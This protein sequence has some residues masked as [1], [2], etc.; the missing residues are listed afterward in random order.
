MRDVRIRY[1]LTALLAT[2]LLLPGLLIARLTPAAVA[3]TKRP[4]S[5]QRIS[6]PATTNIVK[7][8]ELVAHAPW[9]GLQVLSDP[10]PL[11]EVPPAQPAPAMGAAAGILIDVD[12]GGI[13]WQQNPHASLPP[14]STTKIVTAM[15][16]LRNFDPQQLI[17]ITPEALHQAWDETKMGLVSGEKV[18]V[19]D[20]VT[21]ALLVSGNDAA[22]AL[23]MDTVGM[24]N[25]VEA[26]NSQVRALGL[27]DTHFVTPVGLDDPGQRAS[28][29]DLAVLAR[30]AVQTYPLFRRIVA[31]PAATIPATATH[32]QFDLYNLNELVHTYPGAVGVKPGW[33]GSAG[34]CLVGMATRG[35]HQLLSVLL[36]A[37]LPATQTKRLFDWGFTEEESAAHRPR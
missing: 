7:A 2:A 11:H 37:P 1:G 20:L 8:P 6:A 34:S 14:A 17:T 21:G 29:H 22:D 25:F 4:P 35:G 36:N 13:L 32:H 26:M 12:T 24:E 10:S 31:T 15:V 28:A 19:E 9:F 30:T 27:H 33:T 16:A 5:H 3:V 23:A 18:S